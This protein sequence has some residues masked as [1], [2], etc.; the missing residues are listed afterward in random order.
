MIKLYYMTK[1]SHLKNISDS[2]LQFDVFFAVWKL[3][4]LTED[5]YAFFKE[6]MEYDSGTN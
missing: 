5:R 2:K 1:I 4:L 6:Y 3:G